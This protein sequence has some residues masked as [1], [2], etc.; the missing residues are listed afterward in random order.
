MNLALR[1]TAAGRL[2]PH[3]LLQT[4]QSARR[5][6]DR[7]HPVNTPKPT[8]ARVGIQGAKAGMN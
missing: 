4:G 6:R 5:I 3:G 1:M 8:I 2:L 7:R